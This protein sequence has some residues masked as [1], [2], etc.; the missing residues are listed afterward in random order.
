MTLELGLLIINLS[1]IVNIGAEG[2]MLI[3]SLMAVI[4]SHYSGNVWCGAGLAMFAGAV[5]GLLYAFLTVTVKANQIVI[6]AA[7]NILG[8]GLSITI[9][10]IVFGV[11]TTLTKFDSFKNIRI[12]FLADIPVIGEAFFAQML[13]VYVAAALVL[14]CNYFFFHTQSGLDLRAV[15][16]DPRVAD[17]LGIHVYRIRYTAIIVG[18][19]LIAFGG[20][21]LSTG[22]VSS[23]SEE[24]VA[25][26]G[27]IALA[28]VI[29]GK[30]KPTGVALAAVLFMAGNVLSNILQVAGMEIPYTILA[31]IPYI[32]TIVALA[33]LAR[34]AEAPAGLGKPYYKG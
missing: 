9:N 7:V 28:A 19:I 31:M 33:A 10:R 14:L 6:G 5:L 8:S 12:P 24:M 15:G 32:L 26:R 1:G 20:A 22:L 17:T 16:E 11:G 3:A 25:G 4:G 30:Y 21:Y 34:G 29:F 13:P 27:Y 2:N 18:N 23:F